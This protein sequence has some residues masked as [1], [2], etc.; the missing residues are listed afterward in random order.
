MMLKVHL[1]IRN[2]TGDNTGVLHLMKNQTLVLSQSKTINTSMQL[3]PSL[4]P[5]CLPGNSIMED[6]ICHK[7][8]CTKERQ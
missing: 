8:W 1:S 4:F 3:Y 6:T 2:I 7:W 5:T